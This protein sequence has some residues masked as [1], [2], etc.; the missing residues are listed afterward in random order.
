MTDFEGNFVRAV[1][2]VS[3]AAE[4]L[5][6]HV[7]QSVWTDRLHDVVAGFVLSAARVCDHYKAMEKHYDDRKKKL[8]AGGAAPAETTV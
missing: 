8:D 7:N 2:D 4:E 6:K 3:Q 5:R 1:G